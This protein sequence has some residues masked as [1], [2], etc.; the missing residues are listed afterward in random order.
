MQQQRTFQTAEES[1]SQ[2]QITVI[3][4]KQSRL[5]VDFNELW[6]YR[7]LLLVLIQR[8]LKLRYR[9]TVL[10]A[11]WAVLQPVLPMILF[12]LL[13]GRLARFPSDGLPYPIFVFAGLLPWIFFSTG[14]TSSTNSVVN[15]AAF[16]TKV[17]FP[18]LL[19]P[20]ASVFG[21]LI[22]L[23]ISAVIV[24]GMMLYYR[25]QLTSNMLILPLLLFM[26]TALTVAVG[27]WTSALYVKYHD[28]RHAL[29]FV[30]QVWMYVTPVIYPITFIPSRFHWLLRLNPLTGI[31]AGFRS[32]LFGR[33]VPWFVL[34]VSG[35][36]TAIVLL[37][38]S[39]AFNRMEREMAD[40]I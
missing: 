34:G 18:R 4:A 32:A 40:I 35:L 15:S 11:I 28:V 14:V 16:V 17:Y 21:S 37:L 9:Q 33:P 19:L 24:A 30:L 12:S 23:A 2:T 29:P 7:D 10:G 6:H 25:L 1:M 36:L 20:A 31:I 22:D 13:F 38:A 26:I 39:V 27:T 3:D 5:R 8:D